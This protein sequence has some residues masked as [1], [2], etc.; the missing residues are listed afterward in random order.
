ME[1]GEIE[2]ALAG[3]TDPTTAPALAEALGYKDA[4][5]VTRACR[6]GR[7]PGAWKVGRVYLIPL[8]GIHRAI[9]SGTLQPGHK[10]KPL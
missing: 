8:D 2:K 7:I 4:A 6:E 10:S 3:L 5:S 9:E 1:P